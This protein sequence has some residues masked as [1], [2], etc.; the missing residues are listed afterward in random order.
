MKKTA[1]IVEQVLSEAKARSSKGKQA[2][3]RTQQSSRVPNDETHNEQLVSPRRDARA[4]EWEFDTCEDEQL[5]KMLDDAKKFVCALADSQTPYWLVML[6]VPGI[7]KTHLIKR[8][9]NYVGRSG[10]FYR[11]PQTGATCVHRYHSIDCRQFSDQLRNG[12][13]G[14]VDELIDAWFVALDDI[15]AEHDPNGFIASKL[16]R[17]LSGRLGKWTVITSN[18]RMADMEERL[19]PRIASRLLRNESVVLE[20]VT[21]DYNQR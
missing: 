2:S 3:T 7:G 5:V 17:V 16:D 20:I 18:L 8:I 13:F 6:G 1:E 19:D 11:E 12:A 15:G 9:V 14:M 21:T 4:I 10:Q